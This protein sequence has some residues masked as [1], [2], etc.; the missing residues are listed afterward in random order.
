MEIYRFISPLFKLKLKKN[1]KNVKWKPYYQWLFYGLYIIAID[2]VSVFLIFLAQ[3]VV[4]I[5]DYAPL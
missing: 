2:I 5:M 3:T 4:K 1:V